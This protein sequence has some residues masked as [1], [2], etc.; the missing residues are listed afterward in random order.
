MAPDQ[1]PECRP[2]ATR[3]CLDGHPTWINSCGVIGDRIATCMAMEICEDGA[4]NCTTTGSGVRGCYGNEVYRFNDCGE[5]AYPIQA[6]GAREMCVNGSCVPAGCNAEEEACDGQD[7]DCDGTVDEGQLCADGSMC[8]EGRCGM[9]GGLCSPCEQNEDCAEN[10]T[11]GG[12]STFPDLTRVC[13]PINCTSD[14]QCPTDTACNDNGM[15]WLTW[16]QECRDGNSWNVDTCNRAIRVAESCGQDGMCENGRC[17]GE[18]TL[19]DNCDGNRDCASDHQCRGYSSYDHVPMV[20]VPVSNCNEDDGMTCPDD[21][22]CSESGVCW[23]TWNSQCH[24]DGDPWEFDSCGRR[25]V[26]AEQCA[27]GSVCEDGRCVGEGQL[28]ENCEADGDCGAGF[29]CRGYQSFPEI[30]KVCVAISDCAE[31]PMSIC[32]EGFD[33]GSS[34]VCW[35][36]WRQS[37]GE[38][39][40]EVVNVDTCGRT[41]SV[42]ETCEEMQHCAEGICIAGPPLIVDAGVGL[43]DAA[44]M[45]ADAGVAP[46]DAAIM[47]ARDAGDADQGSRDGGVVLGD[48]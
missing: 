20:C 22:Q 32:P 33:C 24:D 23:M 11:C 4:C 38:D 1:A 27:D 30:P 28:C 26:R 46:I 31:N 14:A 25:V 15:C 3:R 35:L 36:T 19:C 2:E 29:L 34:G 13:V 6:C 12:Y 7:N 39:P 9:P 18:G 45:G 48:N 41:V 43:I 8:T 40:R 44:I 37:C 47:G 16:H 21:L 5:P 10:H 42:A 17:I